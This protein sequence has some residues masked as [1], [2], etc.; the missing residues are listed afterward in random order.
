LKPQDEEL[1]RA[2][3]S[4][5]LSLISHELRTPLMGILNSLS[6]LGDAVGG[7]PDA[8]VGIPPIELVQMAR[9]NANRLN[10]T[11]AALLD[12]AQLESGV[13]HARLREIDFAKTVKNRVDS[14]EGELR[15]SALEAKFHAAKAV[16]ILADAQ[17][18]VR[19]VDLCLQA[20]MPRAKRE[21]V[22][23]ITINGAVVEFSF[24]MKPESLENWQQAWFQAQAGFQGGIASPTSAFAGVLQSEQAFLTRSEEGL[25][26]EFLLLHEIMRLHHGRFL[27]KR[28]TSSEGD[29]FSL[30]LEFT[31]VETEDDVR[32]ILTSR[33]YDVSTELATVALV[34]MDVPKGQSSEAFAELLKSHLFR[35]SDAVYPLPE[36][37]QI[38]LVIDDCKAEDI[39]G[40]LSRIKQGLPEGAFSSRLGWAQCP[41]DGHDPGLLFDLAAER[42]KEKT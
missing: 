30:L 18:V 37:S 20:I 16:P 5:L 42:I 14:I 7:G 39:P 40:L 4:N 27:E 36:R 21:S 10:R 22:I 41:A 17:K 6:M 24:Q 38:A 31:R 23:Q 25:G 9:Q 35:S 3:Q 26:S 2:F 29:V 34:L 11:L 15:D 19:A 13:F 8:D 1:F 28:R 32:A 33:A 12:L